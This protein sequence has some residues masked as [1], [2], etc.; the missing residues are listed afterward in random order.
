MFWK[1]IQR[2]NGLPVSILPSEVKCFTIILVIYMHL[3]GE[4]YRPVRLLL[5]HLLWEL[6]YT[7]KFKMVITLWRDICLWVSSKNTKCLHCSYYAYANGKFMFTF[8]SGICVSFYAKVQNRYIS[9][10]RHQLCHYGAG[11]GAVCWVLLS[12]RILR[13]TTGSMVVYLVA[14]HRNMSVLT[15]PLNPDIYHKWACRHLSG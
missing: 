14:C 9:V 15:L 12:Q 2:I 5:R 4:F 11:G 1:C 8:T 10:A 7:W 6:T 13:H 3:R